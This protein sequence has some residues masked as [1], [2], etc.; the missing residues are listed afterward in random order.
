MVS[1][2]SV[3]PVKAKVHTIRTKP[4]VL[5]FFNNKGLGFTN[6][7]PRGTTMNVSFIMRPWACL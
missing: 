7:V 4:M 6:Y 2:G 5:A 3:G 1:Q